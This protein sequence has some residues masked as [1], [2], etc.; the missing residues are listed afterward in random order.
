M[1]FTAAEG[2][3]A[4]G[5]VTRQESLYITGRAGSDAYQVPPT[6]PMSMLR[7]EGTAEARWQ[8]NERGAGWQIE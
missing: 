8:A 3:E 2:T 1:A 5:C 7:G 6:P 4:G